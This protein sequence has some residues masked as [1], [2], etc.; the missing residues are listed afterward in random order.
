MPPVPTPQRPSSASAP[1][2]PAAS[3]PA[4]ASGDSSGE[5]E[6]TQSTPTYAPASLLPLLRA[7]SLRPL[8]VAPYEGAL[9]AWPRQVWQSL[10]RLEALELAGRDGPLAE[11]QTEVDASHRRVLV[12]WLLGLSCSDEMLSVERVTL[13]LAVAWIDR[14]LRI[15]VIPLEKL[16]LLGAACYFISAKLEEVDW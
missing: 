15:K 5:A 10:L 4:A 8:S 12:D 6:G 3:A 9:D 13:A 14:M 7:P 11:I 2:S 16:Q 1:S